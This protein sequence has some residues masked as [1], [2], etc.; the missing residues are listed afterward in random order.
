MNRRV[1]SKILL[2]AMMLLL[3]VPAFGS[4]TTIE[5]AY[6]AVTLKV[7]VPGSGRAIINPYGLPIKLGE[8]SI[9]G[10][11]I[12]TGTALALQ[13]KSDVSL[14]VE[15]E[16]TVKIP[17]TATE[18]TYDNT[19]IPASTGDGTV[20]DK[21]FN[22]VLEVF[23]DNTFEG[24]NIDKEALNAKFAALKSASAS[25]VAS[26]DRIASAG[27]T[28]STASGVGGG[29]GSVI[30]K[31]GSAGNLQK[32]S[33]A[34]FRLSGN[35]VKKPTT[36]WD[37]AKDGFIVT[38][39][40]TFTPTPWT[41]N[42]TYSATTANTTLA[43]NATASCT[44]PLPDGL[45]V[46]QV[47]EVRWV[48][49]VPSVATVGDLANLTTGST[50]AAEINVINNTGTTDITVSFTGPDGTIYKSAPLKITAS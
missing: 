49:S 2:V 35:V 39:A 23:K 20:T 38:V 45:T 42:L 25:M 26:P 24:D 6:Q 40:W 32:G 28:Y 9:S 13:N 48:S 18:I 36:A 33:V 31:Q 29:D 43:Q 15:A 12:T 4:S 37:A 14:D 30:L 16:I 11:Q 19:L 46:D 50:L 8:S 3:A 22:V 41:E 27:A 5:G 21:R 47:T 17:S 10:Q 34:L 7:T 44:L 1:V